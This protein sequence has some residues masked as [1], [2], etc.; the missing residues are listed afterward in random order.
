MFNCQSP[1]P[2]LNQTGYIR[3][4]C[5]PSTLL[6][7]IPSIFHTCLT[8]F[9]ANLC[10]FC[11]L[12]LCV[13]VGPGGLTVLDRETAGS[14]RTERGAGVQMSR[15]VV[16]AINWER[17]LSLREVNAKALLLMPIQY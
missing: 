10:D 9:S 12:G 14:R 17:E 11:L 1:K 2:G 6:S 4:G 3:K 16:L 8:V 13:N 15:C 7:R 5:A